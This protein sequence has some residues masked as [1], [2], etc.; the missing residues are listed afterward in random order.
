MSVCTKIHRYSGIF[1]LGSSRG[2]GPSFFTHDGGLTKKG[3]RKR[4]QKLKRQDWDRLDGLGDCTIASAPSPLVSTPPSPLVRPFCAHP[5]SRH[6]LPVV[7]QSFT[8]LPT[9]P[10][11]PATEWATWQ[12][13]ICSGVLCMM[14]SISFDAERRK[15]CFLW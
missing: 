9:L 2:G 3:K 4:N 5:S 6:S 7:Y 12:L 11:S 13:S 14:H 10:T 15:R 8:N 1:L